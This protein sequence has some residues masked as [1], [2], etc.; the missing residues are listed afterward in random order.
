MHH[1]LRVGIIGV[2]GGW[3]KDSHVP[4]VQ[5]LTGVELVAGELKV[6]QTFIL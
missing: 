4:A 6:M 2:T 1:S 3:A 5:Q